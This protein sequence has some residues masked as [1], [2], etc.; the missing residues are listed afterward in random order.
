MRHLRHSFATRSLAGFY[1]SGKDPNTYL[2]VL[3]TF[4]GHACLTYTARYLHPQAALLKVA[5]DRFQEHVHQVADLYVGG[6]YV[7]C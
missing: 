2:P 6:E 4:L 5:S 3:A 7:S 1:Q